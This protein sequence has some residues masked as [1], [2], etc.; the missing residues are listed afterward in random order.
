MP[1]PPSGYQAPYKLYQPKFSM[2]SSGT[3]ITM[4]FGIASGVVANVNS[5]TSSWGYS[6]T[7]PDVSGELYM[8]APNP[9]SNS[10]GRL[11][12]LKDG[13]P[14]DSTNDGNGFRGPITFGYAITPA[15]NGDPVNPTQSEFVSIATLPTTTY[16]SQ[17][18]VN[19]IVPQI[20]VQSIAAQFAVPSQPSYLW[21]GYKLAGAYAA[22]TRWKS[23][24]FWY[25]NANTT[26]LELDFQPIAT[27]Y[28]P[29]VSIIASGPAK[30]GNS[31]T[32]TITVPN[33]VRTLT[34]SDFTAS[35]GTLSNFTRVS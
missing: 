12:D 33:S 7:T 19:W 14:Q 1:T 27:W 21:V 11:Q 3:Q 35:G 5:S 18:S 9:N 25:S 6:Y 15:A 34:A 10:Y 13:D 23:T 32:L 24:T 31:A 4:T 2:N 22:A 26:M 28:S 20:S 16:A 29:S 17:G 30:V 8:T